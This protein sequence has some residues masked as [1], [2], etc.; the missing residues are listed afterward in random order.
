MQHFPPKFVGLS[1]PLLSA[2]HPRRLVSRCWPA[3]DRRPCHPPRPRFGR[4]SGQRR[5]DRL[6]PC[7]DRRQLAG[8]RGRGHD[9][10]GRHVEGLQGV[11]AGHDREAVE[12]GQGARGR[13]GGGRAVVPRADMGRQVALPFEDHPRLL[14]RAHG[15][16][17]AAPARLGRRAEMGGHRPGIEREA[18]VVRLPVDRRVGAG[19]RDQDRLDAEL[20]RR[21]VRP[22]HGDGVARRARGDGD[23]GARPSQPAHPARGRRPGRGPGQ[24]RD[25]VG[26]DDGR[27]RRQEVA[28]HRRGG[29]RRR[30]EGEVV[31]RAGQLQHAVRWRDI[32]QHA[33][34]VDDAGRHVR[35]AEGQGVA[36][37]D[38]G[39]A[40]PG[41]QRQ[42][43][44][45]PVRAAR[46]A[47]AGGGGDGDRDGEVVVIDAVD[48][49][50]LADDGAAEARAPV[51]RR[52]LPGDAPEVVAQRGAVAGRDVEP[53]DHRRVL[54][55]EHREGE[56]G[57][58]I[59]GRGVG[60]D[61]VA[62]E[63]QVFERGDRGDA[64]GL[65]IVPDSHPHAMEGQDPDA[66]IRP[67][68]RVLAAHP[69]GGMV[70]HVVEAALVLD[71]A[72]LEAQPPGRDPG[73]IGVDRVH[74]RLGASA[75]R[76]IEVRVFREEVEVLQR[77]VRVV[78]AVSQH[79]RAL[80]RPGLGDDQQV[81]VGDVRAA[82]GLGVGVA[83]IAGPPAEIHPAPRD[84]VLAIGADADPEGGFPNAVEMPR[85][86][87]GDGPG[88]RQ[89]VAR[90]DDP[91]TPYRGCTFWR[92][93]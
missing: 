83:G 10:H 38:R 59:A 61:V 12:P 72:V 21:Q 56:A 88:V 51:G 78:P 93:S 52:D 48:I 19:V 87:P 57:E 35:P 34:G 45:R 2:E 75:A 58:A 29:A 23:R 16:R 13:R 66:I 5:P 27:R 20:G 85:P 22:H 49:P 73:G 77:P 63:E 30:G 28:D 70:G 3:H 44:G 1:V 39:R 26:R 50:R 81:K 43:V 69:V 60:V 8:G 4:A 80:R 41:R 92:K 24:A 54:L 46:G 53:G 89:A 55:V 11:A 90:S 7:A 74:H 91:I 31:G 47:D 67:D 64:G 42:G 15:L 71:Q 40:G 86:K 37:R 6:G 79:V 65:E 9:A 76:A 17:R 36:G 68:L 25:L 84:G 82:V 32:G 18:Q 33:A 62:R 14:Q